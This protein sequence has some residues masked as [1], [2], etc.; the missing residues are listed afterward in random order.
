LFAVV[1][2]VPEAAQTLAR[3]AFHGATRANA[4]ALNRVAV[5]AM[6]LVYGI[7][8][9]HGV[10]KESGSLHATLQDY[11]AVRQHARRDPPSA[12]RRLD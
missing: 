4:H 12:Q 1:V 5:A 2:V 6:T 3:L 11:W 9:F 8:Y 10:R 7:E